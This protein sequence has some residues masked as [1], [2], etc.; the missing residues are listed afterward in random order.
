MLRSRVV[1]PA[2]V[3]VLGCTV[4]AGCPGCPTSATDEDGGPGKSSS[5]GSGGFSRPGSSS[6]ASGM[7]SSG[8][9]GGASGGSPDGGVGSSG[10]GG[11]S[12]GTMGGSSGS[13]VTPDAGPQVASLEVAPNPAAVVASPGVGGQITLSV[14]AVLQDGTRR[15]A[16]G[17][18][19]RSQ[20]PELGAMDMDVFRATGE[21]GGVATVRVRAEGRETTHPVSVSLRESQVEPGVP[22]DLP[23]GFTGQPSGDP[24][25]APV[26]VYPYDQ[27]VVPLNLAPILFQWTSP[28]AVYGYHLRVEGAHGALDLYT[29]QDRISATQGA[30]GRLLET[31]TGE[32]LTVKLES[33][34]APGGVRHVMAQQSIRLARADL[35]GTVYYWALNVGRIVRIDAGSLTPAVL[36]MTGSVTTEGGE[37]YACHTLSRDGTRLAFTFNGGSGP[38]GVVNPSA[39]ATNLL[40]PDGSMVW[41]FAAISPD[42]TKLLTNHANEL[43]LRDI[44]T[45]AELPGNPVA[46]GA[47]H[48]AWAPS[49]DL[50]AYASSIVGTWEVDFSQADITVQTVDPTSGIPLSTLRVIPGGGA[51]TYY[52]NFSPGGNFLVFNRGG[53]SRSELS[54]IRYPA[55]LELADLTGANTTLTV[56][57]RANPQQDSYLPTFS[58]FVEGGYMW[59]AFFSRRDYGLVTAGTTRRQIWVAAVDEL[60]TPGTDSSHPAFWLPGQDVATENM[61][62]FFAPAPCV[63]AGGSC[64]SDLGCCNGNLCRPNAQGMLT[65]TPPEQACALPGDPCG[66]DGEC[67][68]GAGPCFDPGNGMKTCTPPELQC[69]MVGQPCQFDDDCCIGAGTCFGGTGTFVCTPPSMQCRA[70][71]ASCT[72]NE[73]CCPGAGSCVINGETGMMACLR[74]DQLCAAPMASCTTTADCCDNSGS[75][76]LPNATNGMLQCL[77]PQD[78]CRAESQAC[79]TAADCCAPLICD[80]VT[81]TCAL[82][83]G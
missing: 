70:N 82:P 24:T 8:S 21:R 20:N 57:A 53:W 43:R 30:W 49:R 39:S 79:A 81:D 72:R 52:P 64:T 67:C 33:I 23:T 80:D 44:N 13:V 11:G 65:C 58:P 32:T 7:T 69:K 41:N 4:W 50:I 61:S 77:R 71:L 15:P 31:H 60:P 2:L 37:C 56:L 12:S 34:E 59:V 46:T 10:G 73:D 45:G 54:G 63:G 74:P 25:R 40:G 22:A 66:S 14:T 6:G 3:V 36:P 19:Y 26:M 51:A 83:G 27:V 75:V 55:T 42:N 78:Q 48:P 62:S 28:V 38:G 1:H 9:S 68:V 35:T 18:F 47:A 76:C 5:G 29:T 17:P 16:R